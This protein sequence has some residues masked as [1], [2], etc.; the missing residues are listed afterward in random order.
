MDRKKHSQKS[1][2][3]VNSCTTQRYEAL[4][5]TAPPEKMWPAVPKTRRGLR[6]PGSAEDATYKSC[7]ANAFPKYFVLCYP[8]YY[9]NSHPNNIFHAIIYRQ[10]IL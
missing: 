10:Y 2:K 8:S 5:K 9:I 4:P 6:I 3:T 1:I 7:T